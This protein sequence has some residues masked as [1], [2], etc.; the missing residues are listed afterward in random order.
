MHRCLSMN[1]VNHYLL[2]SRLLYARQGWC[3]WVLLWNLRIRNEHTSSG[4]L[5][6]T[7][8]AHNDNMYIHMSINIMKMVSFSYF[9]YLLDFLTF[10][11]Y[12]HPNLSTLSFNRLC[13]DDSFKYA[14]RHIKTAGFFF[15]ISLR[16]HST[17]PLR[18][19][20]LTS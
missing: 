9:A 3:W 19:L 1:F 20:R 7:Q 12:R 15:Y 13:L 11:R 17:C 5:K 2:V 14:L 8:P 18:L 16:S 4:L 10:K 6:L